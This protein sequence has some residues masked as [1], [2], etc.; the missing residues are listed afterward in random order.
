MMTAAQGGFPEV[1]NPAQWISF[2]NDIVQA[3]NQA[4]LIVVDKTPSVFEDILETILFSS[5]LSELEEQGKTIFVV[6]A[7]WSTMLV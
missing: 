1:T 6:S 5:V 4:V 3:G 2:K 7:S